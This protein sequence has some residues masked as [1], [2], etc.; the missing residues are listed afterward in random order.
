M[1][2]M[3]K[4]FSWITFISTTLLTVLLLSEVRTQSLALVLPN[5]KIS[6]TDS[7]CIDIKVL[8]FESIASLQTTLSWDSTLLKLKSADSPLGNVQF[9]SEISG[10]V[11]ISWTDFSGQGVSL[12]DSSILFSFCFEV[13]EVDQHLDF[14]LF[15]DALVDTEFSQ[16]N[17]VDLLFI[18]PVQEGGQLEIIPCQSFDLGPDQFV[19][20]GDSTFIQL[21]GD[22]CA[23][24]WWQDDLAYVPENDSTAWLTPGHKYVVTIER[25]ANCQVSDTIFVGKAQ[26]DTTIVF[27]TSC[28][29]FDTS[30]V[31]QTL[32]NQ[33]G[34]DSLVIQNYVPGLLDTTEVFLDSCNPLDTGVVVEHLVNIMGC[35]SVLITHTL[36]SPNC[37]IEATLT[38]Q[39]PIC[40]QENNG[41]ITVEITAGIP[42]FELEL[43]RND[44]SIQIY[45]NVLLDRTI[46]FTDLLSS[47]YLLKVM[48]GAGGMH[49]F[50]V[51][52]EQG[53]APIT[54]VESPD[55][56]CAGDSTYL[57]VLAQEGQ[58][59][60]VYSIDGGLTFDADNTFSPVVAGDYMIIVEDALGCRSKPDLIQL[61]APEPFVIDLGDDLTI[62]LGDS[63]VLE[64]ISDQLIKAISWASDASLTCLDCPRPT[65]RPDKSTLYSVIAENEKGCTGK[66]EI[67]ITVNTEKPIYI[68][69]VFSPNDDGI[70]DVLELFSPSQG[71]LSIKSHIFDRWGNEIFFQEND[72]NSQQGLLWDGSDKNGNRAAN[73]IYVYYIKITS[74][75]DSE[76]QL[77]S[78]EVLLI[79]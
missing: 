1:S 65:A 62:F 48:D 28:Q 56:D 78:G 4:D 44:T 75:E 33:F 39:S 66:A 69:N 31:I 14:I 20:P 46:E 61:Q 6:P 23:Y 11:P 41:S 18:D 71:F 77:I 32:P 22:A 16:F 19:C 15:T 55:I 13:L 21:K 7:F 36:L 30:I 37:E 64:V 67:F 34:C 40:W 51:I 35:D 38:P 45:D 17:G 25:S 60:Y 53:P 68:P 24:L 70:N 59:P 49:D 57:R 8:N 5:V 72:F 74:E 54:T 79:K 2:N 42:P 3:F 27:I 26:T 12:A 10:N 58:G 47:P 9:G 63:V 50:E 73:G 76:T 43:M 52:L 29:S